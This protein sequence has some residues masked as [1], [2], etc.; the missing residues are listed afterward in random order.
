MSKLLLSIIIP[1]SNVEAYIRTCL[2]SIFRQGLDYD[3]FEIILI[4]DG[5]TDRSM[6]VIADIVDANENV[7]VINQGNE[8]PSV[9]RNRGLDKAKG[10]YILFV[11]SDDVLMDNGLSV[12]L[13]TALDTSADVV[14]ADFQRIR[15]EDMLPHYEAQLTDPKPIE[16]T[17]QAFYAE[18]YAPNEGSFIWRS[19]YR[20]DFLDENQI[21]FVPGV[22]YEDIPFIQKCYLRAKLVVRLHLLYYIYRIR[23]RSCT[24]SFSMKNALDYNTAI[25][26]SWHLLETESISN[27]VRSKMQ[28]N[29]YVFFNYAI[30]CIISVFQQP[31]ERKRIIDDLR[32][33]V[34]N[35]RFSSGLKER[36]VSCLFNMMPYKYIAWRLFETKVQNWL[37]ARLKLSV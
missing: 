9:S 31:T 24:Y 23:P 35:L 32:Q 33:K 17:G 11:D 13:K 4:N 37:R 26:D 34:Q 2:E 12:L 30:D 29:I 21:R 10:E 14:V 18:D 22:Y 7:I 8:G 5:S 19:I 25:A 3:C 20:R 36:I 15:D 1:V 6:E 27:E 28:A 16:K